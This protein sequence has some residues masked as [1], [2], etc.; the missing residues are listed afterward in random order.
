M[1]DFTPR[2]ITQR[3]FGGDPHS[4]AKLAGVLAAHF[5]RP[6][7][8][9]GARA[10]AEV[11]D[12]RVVTITVRDRQGEAWPGRWL[13]AVWISATDGGAPGGTQTAAW[14]TG[15]VLATYA[16]NQSWLVMTEADGTAQLS[17]TVTG[18]GTRYVHRAVLGAS[19]PGVPV[20][21]T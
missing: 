19:G 16:A 2:T 5:D 6:I 8:D 14:D 7:A 21:W 4:G 9:A 12:E 1:T 10:S 11:S 3:S 18:A 15:T 17:V 13:V 20:A